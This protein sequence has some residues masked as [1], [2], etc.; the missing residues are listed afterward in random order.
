MPIDRSGASAAEGALSSARTI[1][2]RGDLFGIYPEGTRSHDGRLYRGKTGVARLALETGAPVIP[3]AV[4]GTDVVAPPGKTFGTFTRPGVRFGKPLDFCRYEGMENDR[5]ILRAITDEIMYEIMQLSGQEYVDLYATKAKELSQKSAARLAKRAER[6]ARDE[7]ADRASRSRHPDPAPAAPGPTDR[8]GRDR[9]RGPPLP[10]AG[11][12]P[13]RAR[14]QRRGPQPLPRSASPT[15][16]EGRSCWRGWWSGPAWSAGPTTPTPGVRRPGSSPTSG[17]PWPPWSLTAAV[18]EPGYHSTVPG[19]WVMAAMFAW[20]IHWRMIGG[21]IAAVLL[22]VADFLTRH[23]LSESVYGNLFLLLIGGPIVGLMVDSLLRS[24]TR[25]AAAERA[26]ATAAERA[27]LARAVHDGVLQVLALVQRQGPDLG[28]EGA[29][30]GRLAGEQEHALRT[31]I[32]QQDAVAPTP[33]V[34][35]LVGEL[36]SLERRR[37]VSVAAPSGGVLLDKAEADEIVRRL[38]LPRQRRRPRRSVGPGLGAARG[39]APEA[40]VVTVRDEGPGI[41]EGVSRR[42]RARGGWGW[43]LV[44]S[45]AGVADARRVGHAHH[46][47]PGATAGTE[48]E[49]SVPR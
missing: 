25:T 2:E 14:R 16:S 47:R 29:E 35:D 12:A 3:V 34:V 42:P 44:G 10:L 32:R 46:R 6:E 18:K 13:L 45:A 26:A 4:L 21:L 36:S 37:G 9:G 15:R 23:Y 7:L 33:G 39:R 20:A 8:A 1:L 41:P 48:W 11:G 30:L 43:C 28:P 40:L 31:L 38:V 24:A 27:R 19:F 17:S 5:Y 49:L 22:S